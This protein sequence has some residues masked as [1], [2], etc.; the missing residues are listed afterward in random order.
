M[1]SRWSNHFG[2][3]NP[4]FLHVLEILSDL[5]LELDGK[6]PHNPR[7]DIEPSDF[8]LELSGFEEDPRDTNKNTNFSSQR[9]FLSF[10]V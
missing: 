7:L 1:N 5:K 8:Q 9:E 3:P 10:I 4:T 2:V 6:R